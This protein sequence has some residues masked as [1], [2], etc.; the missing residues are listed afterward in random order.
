MYKKII[1]TCNLL[2]ITFYFFG[3]FMLMSTYAAA[4]FISYEHSE[5]YTVVAPESGITVSL[6]ATPNSITLPTNQ[7]AL[8]WTSTGTPTSCTASSS[9]SNPSVTT[10]SGSRAINSASAE[11][12][13]DLV[14][15]T[16]SFTITCSK[17]GFS[18]ATDTKLVVVSASVTPSGTLTVTNCLITAGNGTCSNT[19]SWTTQNLTAGA[20]AITRNVGTPSSFTPS[21]LS[22]GSTSRTIGYGTTTFYL[23][24]NGAE[25]PLDTKSAVGSCTGGTAWISGSQTCEWIPS[26]DLTATEMNISLGGSSVLKWDSQYASSCTSA[27]FV[28]GNAADNTN[29]GVT[30]SPAATNMYTINCS[31]AGGVATDSVTIVVGGAGLPECSDTIDNDSDT[32]TDYP[33]DVGCSSAFDTTEKQKAFFEEF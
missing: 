27:D 24:H 32:F 22:S 1:K 26:V 30:V 19:V 4:A 3:F 10:W 15:G 23:Y 2:P 14:V 5:N 12:V 20:T 17:A 7:T 11:T 8:T 25:P 33:D 9:L 28:T 29:P 16:Y 21:P 13:S 6:T 31:G 18:D